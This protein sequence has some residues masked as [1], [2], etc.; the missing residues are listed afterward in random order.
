MRLRGAVGVEVGRRNHQVLVGELT[1]KMGKQ[2]LAKHDVVRGV[3]KPRAYRVQVPAA[4][5]CREMDVMTTATNVNVEQRQQ[6]PHPVW[7][8]DLQDQRMPRMIRAVRIRKITTTKEWRWMAL[9]R[10]PQ[11]SE[12]WQNI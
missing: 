4:V 9:N 8:S 10:S 12:N 11:R 5:K 7:P 1:G 6:M 2:G 3:L